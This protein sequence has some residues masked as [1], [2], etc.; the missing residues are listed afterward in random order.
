MVS[1]V[2]LLGLPPAHEELLAPLA[3]TNSYMLALLAL[4]GGELEAVLAGSGSGSSGSCCSGCAG[5]R[6]LMLQLCASE[7]AR[8]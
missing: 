4:L 3:S 7:L 1:A 5:L 2:L 6:T 8:L